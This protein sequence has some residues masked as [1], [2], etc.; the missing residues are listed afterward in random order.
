MGCC[1]GKKWL[2]IV[3][4]VALILVSGNVISFSPWLIIGLYLALK[5]L[6]PMLCKCECCAPTCCVE[7]K[8]KK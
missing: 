3:A 1:D 4:G 2:K 5:G 8:K 7:G 6:L